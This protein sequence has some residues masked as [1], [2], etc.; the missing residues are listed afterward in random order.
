MNF[1]H[2]VYAEFLGVQVSNFFVTVGPIYCV[3]EWFQHA[4]APPHYSRLAR[5]MLDN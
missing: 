1:Q 2:P 4:A 5:K 3:D